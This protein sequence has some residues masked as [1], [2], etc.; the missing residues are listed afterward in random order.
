MSKPN[1]PQGPGRPRIYESS[2]E[3][4]EA[5]RQRLQSAGFMR[6]EVLVTEETWDQVQA[7]AKEQGASAVDV[8]SGL[9]E[10]GL[11]TYP[12]ALRNSSVREEQRGAPKASAHGV[13]REEGGIAKEE[14]RA[15]TRHD[16]SAVTP[17]NPIE[18]FLAKRRESTK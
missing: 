4:V 15:S 17:Q 6:K 2:A 10:H 13:A 11:A 14:N 8:A 5:F 16:K 3:K 7:L 1:T 12:R 18:R 9:L